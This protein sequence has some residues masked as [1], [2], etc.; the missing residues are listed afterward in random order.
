MLRVQGAKHTYDGRA[1]DCTFS[2]I[3]LLSSI[4]LSFSNS[5]AG[6]D[7][8]HHTT[9]PINQTTPH[10]QSINQSKPCWSSTKPAADQA[11]SGYWTHHFRHRRLV[12]E[13]HG[14]ARLDLPDPP[15]V[16]GSLLIL[17][18]LVQ[19]SLLEAT[20][21]KRFTRNQ[22]NEYYH[23]LTAYFDTI[24]DSPRAVPDLSALFEYSH[25]LLPG[26]LTSLVANDLLE[27]LRIIVHHEH[28]HV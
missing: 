24:R 15:Q 10:H 25:D 21:Q 3:S 2:L 19:V 12:C 4:I 1:A 26:T 13:H 20:I 18:D 7:C 28:A 27:L 16:L 5:R 14:R 9:P 11:I 6:S 8:S 23:L 22:I 17:L